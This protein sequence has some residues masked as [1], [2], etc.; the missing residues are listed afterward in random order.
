MTHGAHERRGTLRLTIP[1]RL[2]DLGRA[3]VATAVEASSI[4]GG[5]RSGRPI[6]AQRATLPAEVKGV[7]SNPPAKDFARAFARAGLGDGVL[8]RFIGSN[9]PHCAVD[10]T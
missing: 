4:F 7:R 9:R 5:R 3:R 8:A 1:R 2:F 10:A 6:Q